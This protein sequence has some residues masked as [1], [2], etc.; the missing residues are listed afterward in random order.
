[1]NCNGDPQVI[2]YNVRM[3]DPETE[4]VLPRIKSDLLDLFEGVG[5]GNLHE[6]SFEVDTRFATTV[7]LV[8]GGYPEEY[9]KGDVMTGFENVKDS[10]AF[11][12]GTKQEGDKVVTNGG[13]VI[14]ITSFG[15]T[16]KEALQKSF[17]NA[18]Q[19]KYEG[20]YYRSDIGKDLEVY[21][22][23]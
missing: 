17:A 5:N 15:E 23:K 2:E 3:G 12:A 6:K 10:I 8:A 1:M 11:H 20:K 18:E 7:M 21:F 22:S 4:V 9:R 16:M 14:A 13:R 19:I